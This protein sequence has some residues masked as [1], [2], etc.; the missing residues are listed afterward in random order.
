MYF[1]KL[2]FVGLVLFVLAVVGGIKVCDRSHRGAMIEQWQSN[3]KSFQV[4][5]TAYE[6]T[7]ANVNGAYYVFEAA[8]AG[9]DHWREIMIFRHD[10][11]PKIPVDQVRYVNDDI[12]YVF[13]G[14]MYAVTTDAGKTWSVWSAE[15]ALPDW[16]CCNYKL[17]NDVTIGS[18]G[19]GVMRFNPIAGRPGEVSQLHTNDFGR[20]WT[21]P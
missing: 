12:G 19:R 10:D 5:V 6:E 16:Q 1:R 15:K 18:D 7:G 11:D 2:Y 17:I 21:Q 9:S 13:M 4:R 8:S 20:H 3:N 14:W